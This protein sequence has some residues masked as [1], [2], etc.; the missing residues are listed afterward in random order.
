MHLERN[1]EILVYLVNRVIDI[2][3][4]L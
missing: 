3:A 4:S 1:I 2:I